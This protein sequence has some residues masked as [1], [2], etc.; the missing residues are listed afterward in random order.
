MAFKIIVLFRYFQ[1][2]VGTAWRAICV[3]FIMNVTGSG[4]GKPERIRG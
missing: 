1:S 3:K 2:P 4:S